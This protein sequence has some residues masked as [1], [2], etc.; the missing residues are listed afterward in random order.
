MNE[1]ER[2]VRGTIAKNLADHPELIPT[3]EHTVA[4]VLED[5][6]DVGV[7]RLPRGLRTIARVV[8]DEVIEDTVTALDPE[9]SK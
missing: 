9:G 3:V 6:V 8:L 2:K 1:L 4:E 5:V 7:R